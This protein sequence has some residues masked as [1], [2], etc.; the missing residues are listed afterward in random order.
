MVFVNQL[1]NALAN[2]RGMISE[3]ATPY[4]TTALCAASFSLSLCQLTQ[5]LRT[6]L[7]GIPLDSEHG[8]IS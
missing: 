1:E 8:A 2:A 6:S 4:N 5:I 3:V 7:T